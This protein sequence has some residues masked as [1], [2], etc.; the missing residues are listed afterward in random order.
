VAG[1]E[2]DLAAGLLSVDSVPLRKTGLDS[3]TTIETLK[4]NEGLE[5]G[6]WLLKVY[7]DDLVVLFQFKVFA[8]RL[9]MLRSHDEMKSSLRNVG[10]AVSPLK[11]GLRAEGEQLGALELALTSRFAELQSQ[12]SLIDGL[13]GFRVFDHDIYGGPLDGSGLRRRLQASEDQQRKRKA[14]K[15]FFVSTQSKH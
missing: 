12:A 14:K 1:R 9:M 7:F 8:E 5:Y 4:F 11:V 6:L 10:E 3:G 13:P 15:D 2:N